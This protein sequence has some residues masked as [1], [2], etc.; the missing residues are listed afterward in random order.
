MKRFIATLGLVSILFSADGVAQTPLGTGFTYQ[1]ELNNAGNPANGA[2]DLRFRLLNAAAGGSQVGNTLCADNVA[3]TNG[4]FTVSLDFGAQF[5]GQQR[6]LAI[7]V[8]ADTGLDCSNA[9]GFTAL[10]PLQELSAVPNAAF[11][12][13]ATTATTATTASNATLLN[14]QGASFYQNAS[15]LT[16]GT[17]PGGLL[18]G[19]Y[20]SP[21]T[22]SN[23]GNAFT[24]SFSGSGAGLTALNASNL[25]TGTLADAR[26]ST[27]VALL[28]TPQAFTAG[29]TFSGGLSTNAFTLTTGAAAGSVLRSDA[30][31]AG[32]WQPPP[33]PSGAAGGG[34]AGTYPNPSIAAD[35]VLSGN[36]G[37]D[38]ASLGRVSGGAVYTN[39]DFV[40]IGTA[41]GIGAARF[42]VSQNTGGFGG[43]YVNTSA[44]TGLPFYGYAQGG[45][46]AA[47]HYL[48]GGEGN[49]WKLINGGVRMTVTSGGDVGIGTTSPTSRL[50]VVGSG[51][52]ALLVTNTGTGRGATINAQTGTALWA[53]TTSGMAGVDARNANPS[54]MGVYGLASASTGTAYGVAGQSLSAGGIGVLGHASA[55]GGET[56]GVAGRCDST[57]GAGVFGQVTAT[58]GANYGVF[59][60]SDSTSG[61]GVY[62]AAWANS[63]TI[64]GVHGYASASSG[65][66]AVFASGRSGASGTKSFRIDHPDDPENKYLLHYS[67]ESPEIPTAYSGTIALDAAG[68]AVVELPRYFAKINR[69]PRY[70]L[71]AVGAPMPMLHVAEEIDEAALIS[72]ATAGPADV[73]PLCSFR[74]AGGAP[75]RKVSWRVEAVRNDRWIQQHGAPVEVEKS[76]AEK[77]TYQHP[78]LYGRPATEGIGFRPNLS[79]GKAPPSPDHP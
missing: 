10:L 68:G 39:G 38:P 25:G 17:L 28:S 6:F 74:I 22:F 67:T 57:G 79:G 21:L 27:N 53:N 70:T 31:G 1:G 18:S 29:K 58:T 32:T 14:G 42:V 55:G 46:I 36:L 69:N 56:Y 63:G 47:Y 45:S 12:L 4:R 59:G 5:A 71:T 23:A 75:G 52:D 15:N 65:G 19:I 40:G 73:A 9:A 35:A 76:G 78:D 43:M 50:D 37:S 77:G 41:T 34:L 2:Y 60:R 51:G 11:A 49:K 8:R 72:G 54:G 26:L 48:D 24:G 44:A 62:G 3:V 13:A 33:P 7:E 16:A 64:Y 61:T 66:Y 20:S 30:G